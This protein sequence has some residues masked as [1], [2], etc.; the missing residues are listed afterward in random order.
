VK[1]QI[2]G[3]EREFNVSPLTLASLVETLG[4]KPDRVAVE[5]NRDIV[6]RNLWAETSLSEGDKLEVVHFVGGGT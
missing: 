4:M 3:E 2:N 6:P 1:L 5:L